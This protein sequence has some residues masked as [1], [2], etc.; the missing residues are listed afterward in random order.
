MTNIIRILKEFNRK[1]IDVECR[2]LCLFCQHKNICYP[3]A[4]M[5]LDIIYEQDNTIYNKR[6][7]YCYCFELLNNKKLCVYGTLDDWYRDTPSAIY[8]NVTSITTFPVH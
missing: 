2:H 8:T 6:G 1:W 4:K 3:P 7:I 5:V